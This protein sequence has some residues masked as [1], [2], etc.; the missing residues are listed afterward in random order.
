M[1][2]VHR[3]TLKDGQEVVVKVQHQGIKEIILDDLKNAKS[4]V[5]WIAWAEPALD[6]NFL[7]D[8]WH[9]ETI[10]EL[11]FNIEAENTRKVSMNL[12]VKSE[13]GC[14]KLKERVNVLI[15]E[16]IQSTEKVL[17]LQY[18]DG[19]RLNDMDS[20]E[21][22][23][24]SKKNLVREI[25]RAYAHQIYIDGFF[26]GDPHPGNFLVSKEHPHRPILLDFGLTK[27]ISSSMKQALAKMLLACA[28]VDHVA[29]LAAFSEMGFKLR[30]DMPEHAMTVVNLFYANAMPENQQSLAEER[31]KNKQFLKEKR[32]LNKKQNQYFNPVDAFPVDAII[33]MRVI[34]LLQGLS[35]TLHVQIPYLDI[36]R[37]FAE[38]TLLGSGPSTT[39]QWIYNS[40]VHSDVEAKL[41]Q[42]LIELGNEKILGVQVCAYK[43]GKVII[44]TAAGMLGRYDPQPV[45]PDTLFPVFSATKGITAGMVHWLVDKR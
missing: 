19:I 44:D 15:P 39:N 25:T 36:M 41:R 24:V 28:E 7:V 26:N 20:L 22:F 40:P 32:N 11:D 6:F 29:L 18:M 3:A 14:P 21:E 1:A 42:L 16:I 35:R 37:P 8:E 30:V 38:S 31:E 45:Q 13:H 12:G 2:Q 17:I 5:E 10:K 27:S 34:N 33:F 23:G 43:D 4:L 9:K